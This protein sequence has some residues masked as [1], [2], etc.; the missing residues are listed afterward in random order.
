ML[1][2]KGGIVKGQ[3]NPQNHKKYNV[4]NLFLPKYRYACNVDLFQ[5]LLLLSVVSAIT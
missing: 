3:N 2:A 5:V 4:T 1:E